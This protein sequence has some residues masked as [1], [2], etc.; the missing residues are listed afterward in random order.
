VA[1]TTHR[2]GQLVRRQ[3]LVT[4]ALAAA[5]SVIAV[6]AAQGAENRRGMA[7]LRNDIGGRFGLLQVL[8]P[9]RAECRGRT[10]GVSNQGAVPSSRGP[11]NAESYPP[12]FAN[13]ALRSRQAVRR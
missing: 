10:W 2:L 6:P 9:I 12:F 8:G 5:G 1:E 13:P 3:F 11:K 7:E 4:A